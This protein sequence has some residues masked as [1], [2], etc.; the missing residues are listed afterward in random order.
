VRV[1]RGCGG[2]GKGTS[3]PPP[4]AVSP[5]PPGLGSGSRWGVRSRRSTDPC[6]LPLG[7]RLAGGEAGGSGSILLGALARHQQSA[8]AD[9]EPRPS[10]YCSRN[11][12]IADP[13]C[14][15]RPLLKPRL[16]PGF[17]LS[18]DRCASASRETATMPCHSVGQDDAGGLIPPRSLWPGRRGGRTGRLRRGRHARGRRG[19]GHRHIPCLLQT[20]EFFLVELVGGAAGKL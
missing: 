6:P 4:K 20:G 2:R 12:T 9:A 8:H 11:R 3:T 10:Q 15:D 17:F 16:P 19:R 5:S 14:I 18:R 1:F 7:A 13:P